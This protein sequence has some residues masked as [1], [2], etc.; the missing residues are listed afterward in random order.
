MKATHWITFGLVLMALTGFGVIMASA[1]AIKPGDTVETVIQE[2]GKP[3][4]RISSGIYDVFLYDRGKVELKDGL[5]TSVELVSAEVAAARKIA[6][7]KRQQEAVQRALE[8][9]ESRRVEG[10]KVMA[11]HLADTS[12]RTQSAGEQLEYWDL[13]K[14]QYP[15]IDI[16]S[17]YANLSRQYQ[18]EL[19][20]A[21]VREQLADLQQRTAAAEARAL[22][23][24]QAAEEAYSARPTVTYLSPPWIQ[25]YPYNYRPHPSYN[26]T[27][28]DPPK[29]SYQVTHPV[30]VTPA[31]PV[32]PAPRKTPP[33][34][35]P[36]P[37][38]SSSSTGVTFNVKSSWH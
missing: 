26:D 37:G 1:E 30:P 5:V 32:T 2:L 34:K 38:G 25:S 14:N 15:E 22:R 10:A 17:V 36:K 23:A 16:G 6:Q 20:Q 29:H 33:G 7:E 3:Q 35:Y 12:F 8:L 27:R 24:E 11:D 28:P 31:C 21:R 4:G 9:R 19:E 18:V 13:F